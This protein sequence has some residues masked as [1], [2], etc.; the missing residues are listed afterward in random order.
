MAPSP[1]L[2]IPIK[3]WAVAFS[4]R[5]PIACSGEVLPKIKR[6]RGEKVLNLISFELGALGG[7]LILIP[8]VF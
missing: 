3:I 8:Y 1:A 4:S 2:K 5:Q 6:K 7:K